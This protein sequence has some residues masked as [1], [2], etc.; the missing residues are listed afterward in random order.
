MVSYHGRDEFDAADIIDWSQ[1]RGACDHEGQ[2]GRFKP[3]GTFVNNQ[4][5]EAYVNFDTRTAS[6]YNVSKIST[7]QTLRSK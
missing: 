5:W 4:A 7:V 6:V 3:K 1:T 2:G